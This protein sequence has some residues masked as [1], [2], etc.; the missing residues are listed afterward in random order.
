MWAK[1]IVASFVVFALFIV[2]LVV[3]CVKQDIS[4]ES[5]DYYKDE[6]AYQQKIDSRNNTE[7]LHQKP[8]I[9]ISGTDQVLSV[10]FVNPTG[11]NGKANFYKPDQAKN[12]F[13]VNFEKNISLDMSKKA[14]GLWKV[15]LNWKQN[16]KDFY[17][18][19]S[20]FV[21]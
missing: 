11:L 8:T 18:E 19:E 16:G 6:L 5:K 21:N 13:E 9:N 10:N 2:T 14:P 7:T 3:I 20:I 1:G 15:K 12:D 4:L 17:Y